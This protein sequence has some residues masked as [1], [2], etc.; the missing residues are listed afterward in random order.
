M[1]VLKHSEEEVSSN[2]LSATLKSI[3]EHFNFRGA[4]ISVI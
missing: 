3:E 2:A 1:G 4:R